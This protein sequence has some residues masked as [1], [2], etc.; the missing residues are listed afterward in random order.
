MN[1]SPS[2]HQVVL[3]TCPD[4]KTARHIAEELVGSGQAACVNI[5]PQI[6]SVYRWQG[7]IESDQELLL[8]IKTVESSWPS[9][10]ATV[11]RLHPYDVPEIISLPVQQG[12]EA[13]LKWMES[14]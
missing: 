2:L 5:V 6:Q 7:K 13:Y 4:E 8:I 1:A 3:V 10:K 9:L 14:P 11:S 12:S